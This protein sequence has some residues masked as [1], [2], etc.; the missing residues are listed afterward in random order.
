MGARGRGGV[1][2]FHSPFEALVVVSRLFGDDEEARGQSGSSLPKG[3]FVHF[4]L[5]TFEH[6]E[7]LKID[8]YPTNEGHGIRWISRILALTI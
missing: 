6:R 4:I 1:D 5:G 2:N 7:I 8:L 3:E